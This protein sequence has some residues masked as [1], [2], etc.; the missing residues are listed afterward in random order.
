MMR[1]WGQVVLGAL[2]WQLLEKAGLLLVLPWG[3]YVWR[4]RITKAGSRLSQRHTKLTLL[5]TK[6]PISTATKD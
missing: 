4:K 5:M 1:R 3:V 6:T 2:E